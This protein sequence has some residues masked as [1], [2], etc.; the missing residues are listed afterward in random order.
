MSA[1]L[2]IVLFLISSCSNSTETQKGES[3]PA[4]QEKSASSERREAGDIPDQIKVSAD[5]ENLQQAFRNV[6]EAVLPVVVEVN[7]IQL[8]QQT[9]PQGNSPW[10]FFFGP[11]QPE[12]KEFRRPGLGSGVIVRKA[13]DTVYVVT[14]NHV[15]GQAEEI[16]V[17]LNNGREFTAQIVG[18]DRR[19]DLALIKFSSSSDIPVARLGDSDELFVG[20]WVV[21]AGN[22]FGF[23]STITS[24]IISA[25]GRTPQQGTPVAGFTSYIQ[26][27]ASINPGNSGGA[28]ADLQG[29]IIG[30]NTWIASQSGG[31]VGL[32]FAIPINDVKSAVDSFIENGKIIYGWLGVSI[33]DPGIIPGVREEMRLGTREGAVII[34]IYAESPAATDGLLPGDLVMEIDGEKIDGSR[35]LTRIVGSQ[36]PGETVE[37]SLL[38][39][40]TEKTVSV[41]LDERAS[42]ETIQSNTKLWPGTAAAGITDE[43]RNDL[44]IP[45]D[46]D[47]VILLNVI[48]NSPAA[49]A[50]LRNGDLVIEL[51]G[52]E[53]S[54]VMDYY[55]NINDASIDE[56]RYRI[57]RNGREVLIGVRRP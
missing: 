44:Q 34:N 43:I 16:S 11:Q 51:N 56:Y 19:T 37:F 2:L 17:V 50:G 53:L 21:A 6:A 7:V 1:A 38:R 14:N 49:N 55:Q 33:Q 47:G 27:D 15:V 24:G 35:K 45:S 54:S 12:E 40:G 46:V 52:T 57:I 42:E 9:V 32:G 28:L 39:Y 30:I 31:S 10:D 20:D 25:L 36:R 26:T 8:V 5:V 3:S 41:T 48:G 29:R 22:P 4:S 18:K 23:E 13:G